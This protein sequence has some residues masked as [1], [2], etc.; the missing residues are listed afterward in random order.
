MGK[1][2]LNLVIEGIPKDLEVMAIES[3]KYDVIL[4]M[5][6]IKLFDSKDK[7]D[8]QESE[9]NGE[10]VKSDWRKALGRSSF[11]QEMKE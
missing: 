2:N 3:L 11:R 9:P 10:Y 7:Q 1:L 6:F 8:R 5:D 4:G